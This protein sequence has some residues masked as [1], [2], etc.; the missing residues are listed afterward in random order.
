[1]EFLK[2]HGFW[3]ASRPDPRAQGR[4]CMMRLKH[5]AWFIISNE[6]GTLSLYLLEDA[7]EK[8][9]WAFFDKIN[10]HHGWKAMRP[11]LYIMDDKNHPSPPHD[12]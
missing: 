10:K 7:S 3:E 11:N 6:A 5:N 9:A 1:V 8:Q 12:N 4:D 2:E